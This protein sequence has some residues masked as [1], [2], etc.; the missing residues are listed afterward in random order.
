MIY[1]IIFCLKTHSAV[2]LVLSEDIRKY[3]VIQLSEILIFEG[4]VPYIAVISQ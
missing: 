1:G 4:D 3:L 2:A